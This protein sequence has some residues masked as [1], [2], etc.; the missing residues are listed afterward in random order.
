MKRTCCMGLLAAVLAVDVYAGAETPFRRGD[1]NNDGRVSIAD[2]MRLLN[3]FKSGGPLPDCL[4]AGDFD[5]SG[6]LNITDAIGLLNFLVAGGPAPEAPYPDCG[7]ATEDFQMPCDAEPRCTEVVPPRSTG[8]FV[9]FA[10]DA[11]SE[12]SASEIVVTGA[13][14]EEVDVPFVVLLSET[15]D[16]GGARAWSIPVG[17]ETIEGGARISS[18]TTAGT[19][20]ASLRDDP[21]GRVQGFSTAAITSNGGYGAAVISFTSPDRLEDSNSVLRGTAR[22]TIPEVGES[23]VFVGP[24]Q[25]VQGSGPPID[26]EVVYEGVAYLPE[27]QVL[28]IRARPADAGTLFRRGRVNG[29]DAFNIADPVALLNWLFATG[30]AP[31]CLDSADMN[32]DGRVNISD[33]V[34]GLGGLFA[35]GS[36]PRDP[37]VDCGVDPTPD[38]LTCEVSVDCGES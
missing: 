5:A 1:T 4:R 6:G 3:S 11:G 35:G 15:L 29:D 12:G 26:L 21:V 37:F 30:D 24:S 13:P 2:V 32:D 25:G 22:V 16:D 31:E 14:K 10:A 18:V 23:V 38:A 34:F 19:A 20:S 8:F 36:L 7:V 9:T 28:R 33:A 27:F 17:V